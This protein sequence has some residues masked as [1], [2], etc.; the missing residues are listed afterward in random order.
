MKW[1]KVAVALGAVAS[2]PA[3]MI[4]GY[5]IADFVY[6]HFVFKGDVTDLTPGS[7]F[8]VFFL[9]CVFSGVFFC[10]IRL[11]GCV[12]T[13]GFQTDFENSPLPARHPD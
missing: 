10:S 12:F 7:A 4:A 1:K 6:M 9:T 13:A 11:F 3:A 2:V 8:A 5:M